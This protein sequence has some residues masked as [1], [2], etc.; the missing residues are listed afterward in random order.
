MVVGI[1]RLTLS[2]P[3]AHSLKDKRRVVHKIVERAR[4]RYNASIAEVGDNDLW[5]RAQLGVSVVANDRRFVDEVL[6]KLTR[7]VEA[8]ADASLLQREVEIETYSQMAEMP[9]DKPVIDPELQEDWD[10][11]AEERALAETASDESK[12]APSE[13]TAGWLTESDLEGHQ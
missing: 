3:G 10:V 9:P 12:A 5:Q 11:E 6:S 1:L 7:D 2:I 8:N 4:S 13:G